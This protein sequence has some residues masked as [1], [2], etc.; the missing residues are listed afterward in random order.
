[1]R[2]DV[3]ND[4]ANVEN[5]PNIESKKG[6]L[7]DEQKATAGVR[8]TLQPLQLSA[9]GKTNLVGGGRSPM[10]S[11]KEKNQQVH[12]DSKPMKKLKSSE[13]QKQIIVETPKNHVTAEDLT[14]EES[15][16]AEYWKALAER[17]RE[18]LENALIENQRL[19]E[20]VAI[21][22]EE[23]SKVAELLN[24]STQIIES[25]TEM[26]N[27]SGIGTEIESP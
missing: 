24:E 19:T 8:R 23:N 17:R 7:A 20:R 26:L 13:Q 25:L 12:V 15:P 10:P 1:M 2:T 27:E 11:N 18:A 22:E 21:L 4:R 6:K 16:S 9:G 14:T 3:A 5:C